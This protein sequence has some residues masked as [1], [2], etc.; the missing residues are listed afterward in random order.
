MPNFGSLTSLFNLPRTA[1]IGILQDYITKPFLLAIANLAGAIGD[2]L[3]AT[4]HNQGCPFSHLLPGQTGGPLHTNKTR[5]KTKP[6]LPKLLQNWALDWKFGPPREVVK[7]MPS[8]CTPCHQNWGPTSCPCGINNS[9]A[10]VG[11]K[12][13]GQTRQTSQSQWTARMRSQAHWQ[14]GTGPSSCKASMKN[15]F[16]ALLQLG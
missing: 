14:R 8:S 12:R 9:S 11:N 13:L 16:S 4:L 10:K 3:R 5:L 6:R 1:E 2:A 15:V 7:T